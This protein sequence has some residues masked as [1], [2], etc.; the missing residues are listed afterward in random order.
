MRPSWRAVLFM[1]G[2]VASIVLVA[3][4]TAQ[5]GISL[6]DLGN[7]ALLLLAVVQ[8]G[9]TLQYLLKSPWWVNELG[10][11]YATKSVIMT[12]VLW[13]VSASV[14]SQSQYPGREYW[15]LVIYVGGAL[16]MVWLWWSLRQYQRRGRED[17][18]Q[19]GDFRTQRR[20]W[21]DTLRELAHKGRGA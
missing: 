4:G 19:H 13:Q 15:R 3:L 14:I 16:A 1:I 17:R 9:F 10:R 18:E 5:P 2:V 21:V 8:I 12:L 6:R 7:G 11:I 20:I